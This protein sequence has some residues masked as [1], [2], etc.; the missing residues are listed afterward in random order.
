[1]E[2]ILADEAV[3]RPRLDAAIPATALWSANAALQR[4]LRRRGRRRAWWSASV[5]VAA[6][7]AAAVVVLAVLLRGGPQ[8]PV[9]P[10]PAVA[11]TSEQA[12]N[13]FFGGHASPVDA[14]MDMLGEQLASLESVSAEPPESALDMQIDAV[15]EN[16]QNFW[17][18]PT[19]ASGNVF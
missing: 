2:E 16:L 18:E 7:A 4:A 3:V 12:V 8:G 15:D 19:D 1:M 5:S 11:L 17:L 10:A 6:S 14:E 13:A 9:S